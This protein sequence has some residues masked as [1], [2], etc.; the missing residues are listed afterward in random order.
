MDW[1]KAK[2]IIIIALLMTNL[3]MG[4]FYLSGYREDMQERKLAAE[5]AV[6]YAAQKGVTVSTELPADLKKLP[7]LFV[8]LNYDGSGKLHSHRGLPV[9]ASGDFGGEIVPESEGETGGLLIPA[10]KALLK[11]LDSFG[12]N[13]PEGLDIDKVSLVYW[14]DTSFSGGYALEDTAIPAWKFESGSDCYYIEAFAE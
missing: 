7:V 13:I 12:G 1:S 11:L 8:S 4:G 14:V 2:T 6:Q 5:S 3:L 10:S 9:E